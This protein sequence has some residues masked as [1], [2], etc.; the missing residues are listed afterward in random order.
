MLTALE[1]AKGAEMDLDA[2]ADRAEVSRTSSGLNTGLRELAALDLIVK[3][4][5]GYRLSP[6]FL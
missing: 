4:D 5:G 6:D 3:T 1:T 2:I